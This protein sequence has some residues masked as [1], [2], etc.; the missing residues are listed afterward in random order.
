LHQSISNNLNEKF[1][2]VIEK[3]PRFGENYSK[4]DEKHAKLK[5]VFNQNL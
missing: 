2:D 1:W 3:Y 5:K 4:R